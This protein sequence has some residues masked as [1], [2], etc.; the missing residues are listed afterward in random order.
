MISLLS[1]FFSVA[2]V[3]PALEKLGCALLPCESFISQTHIAM[4]EFLVETLYL[5]IWIANSI[6]LFM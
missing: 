4:Y 3:I 1:G 2:A 5:G 6:L